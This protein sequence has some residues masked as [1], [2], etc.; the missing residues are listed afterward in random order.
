MASTAISA[1]G[2]TLSISGSA[3]T[4]KTITGISVGNPTIITSA[5]HG[6]GNGDVLTL[7]GLT[8]TDAAS[9]NGKTVVAKNVTANTYVFDIDSTG[10]NLTA[11]GTATPVSWVKIGN[12]TS[13]KGFDGTASEIDVTNMD[14]VAK[15]FRL[16]LQDF[17]HFTFDVDKNFADPGQMACDAAK[18]SATQKNFKLSLPNGTNATFAGY[19]KNSPLDGGVDQTLKTSGVQIRITGNVTFS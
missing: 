12:L 5:A 10:L 11:S 7:S 1:Q 9:L 17:G 16:G 2:S 14:S 15:E 19:V 18:A 6:F 8:G 3:G 4:A 13:F